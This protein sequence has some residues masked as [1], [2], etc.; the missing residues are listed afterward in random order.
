MAVTKAVIAVAGYGTRWLPLTKALEKCMIP[1]LN[2]PVIDYVVEDCIKSW[3][4]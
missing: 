1:V 3:N 4:N 2:R